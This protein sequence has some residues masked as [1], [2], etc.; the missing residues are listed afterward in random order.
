MAS[1]ILPRTKIL[2]SGGGFDSTYL[3]IRRLMAGDRCEAVY[4]AM[5]ID[6]QKQQRELAAQERVLHAL[7]QSLRSRLI[8]PSRPFE[9]DDSAWPVARI[10]NV[11]LERA[12]AD[13]SNSP[14]NGLLCAYGE[15]LFGTH[16]ADSHSARV[17]L[18]W[19]NVGTILGRYII[20][21][22]FS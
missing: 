7:P 2:W 6:W 3:L 5:A 4:M 12:S 21:L 1:I 13:G 16:A 18:L 11:E 20:R 8:R 15:L 19:R 22:G 10:R 17:N 14:Q 9:I